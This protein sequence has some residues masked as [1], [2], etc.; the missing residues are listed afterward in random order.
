M[1]LARTAGLRFTLIPGDRVCG[2]VAQKT[3]HSPTYARPDGTRTCAVICVV[4][5]LLL[6][7]RQWGIK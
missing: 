2:A 7:A 1:V 6:R 3:G 4:C 5:V